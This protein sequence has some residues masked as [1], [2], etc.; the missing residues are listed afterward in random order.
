MKL[1][2]SFDDCASDGRLEP[3]LS[4]SDMVAVWRRRWLRRL[5]ARKMAVCW[6]ARVMEG[7][8]QTTSFSL[9]RHFT[10]LMVLVRSVLVPGC[11]LAGG[12]RREGYLVHLV[13]L[14]VL[15]PDLVQ[16][17]P[18]EDGLDLLGQGR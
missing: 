1:E 18:R 12:E 11:A 7:K 3:M 4:S 17:M 16:V 14:E 15:G 6:K 8:E 9:T 2:A 10:R 5:R 13:R